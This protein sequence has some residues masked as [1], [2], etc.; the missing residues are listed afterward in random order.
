MSKDTFFEQ[1]EREVIETSRIAEQLFYNRQIEL[2][3]GTIPHTS[4]APQP[5][6][7]N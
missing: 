1:R 2:K 6:S 4:S 5:N 3:H 7:G